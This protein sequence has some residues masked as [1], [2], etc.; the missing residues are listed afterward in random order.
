VSESVWPFDHSAERSGLATEDLDTLRCFVIC[1]SSPAALYDDI[2]RV[3]K[4]ICNE[5]FRAYGVKITCKRAL[6]IVSSGVIHPEIWSSIRL[7]DIV[8]ADVSGTN[9]N[10][11]LELG[12]AAAW[13]KKEKVI[14]IRQENPTER[15]LFDIGPA[16]HIEY[17]CTPSGFERLADQLRFTIQDVSSGA[18]FD[19]VEAPKVALPYTARFDGGSDSDSLLTP[20]MAHRRVVPGRFLEF[21][22]LYNFRYGWLTVGDL[23]LNN[24]HVK[25][26]LQFS[27]IFSH[28]QGQPW[29][30]VAVRSQGYLANKEH[31][32]YLH[33]DG[34]VWVTLEEDGGTRHTDVFVGRINHFD[35][36][37]DQ[38]IVFDVLFDDNSWSLQV[39][40]VNWSY[41]TDKLPYV[42]SHGRIMVQGLLCW[43]GMRSLEVQGA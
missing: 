6:D 32:V 23:R 20:G 15:H 10:V 29:I 19:E 14:I 3:I 33:A 5:M 42:F 12:V 35:P 16:R 7:A 4:T 1:P 27:R 11:M 2:F 28:S 26:E 8:I 21:G 37:S 13:H 36:E 38:P 43:V 30:G 9:G 18:P 34:A 17:S 24:V 22:S 40:S 41:S 31:L 25:A 39:G